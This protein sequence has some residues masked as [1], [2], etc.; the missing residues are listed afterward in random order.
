[1]ALATVLIVVIFAL[2][3]RNINFKTGIN[4]NTNGKR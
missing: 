3:A 2:A 1:M 4:I